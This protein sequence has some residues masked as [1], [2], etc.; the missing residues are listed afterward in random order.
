M[1]DRPNS[2]DTRSGGIGGGVFDG[3][4]ED[5]GGMDQRMDEVDRAAADELGSDPPGSGLDLGG[6]DEPLGTDDDES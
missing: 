2:D 4:A 5:Y 1:S 3:A 6:G